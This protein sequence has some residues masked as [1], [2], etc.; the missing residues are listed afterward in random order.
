MSGIVCW[1]GACLGVFGRGGR[2]IASKRHPGATKWNFFLL[3]GELF[4][5]ALLSYPL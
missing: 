3:A 5:V 2:S 1:S 4:A